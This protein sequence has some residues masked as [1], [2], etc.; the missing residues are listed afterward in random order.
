MS[1]HKRSNDDRIFLKCLLA[2]AAESMRLPIVE[3]LLRESAPV[4]TTARR[5]KIDTPLHLAV[6]REKETG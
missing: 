2:K 1:S 5:H 3:F 6:R 4:P